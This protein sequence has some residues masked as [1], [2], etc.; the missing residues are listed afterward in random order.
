MSKTVLFQKIQFSISRKF[1]CQRKVLF[2]TIQFSITKQFQRKKKT[3]L[4]QTIQFSTNKQ[5]NYI[6]SIDMTPSGAIT[7]GQSGPG[8]DSNEGVLCIPQSSS[9]TGIS[10][11]YCLV[12]HLGHPLGE[13]YL[14]AEKQSVFST[15][16]V[17][18]VFMDCYIF[19]YLLTNFQCG[20][21]GNN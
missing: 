2:P 14:S 9:I 16:P 4:F 12:L 10:P 6:W 13:S 20:A 18:N 5:F 11:S 3:F 1:Q 7:P 17:Y 8:S 21:F 15:A 19:R